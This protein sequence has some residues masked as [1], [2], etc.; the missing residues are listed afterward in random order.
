MPR[1]SAFDSLRRVPLRE[2]NANAN[3]RHNTDDPPPASTSGCRY[4][5]VADRSV[6]RRQTIVPRGGVV[7]PLFRGRRPF[8]RLLRR[9]P[10]LPRGRRRRR[11]RPIRG[12]GTA[13]EASRRRNALRYAVGG[14]AD[15]GLPDGRAGRSGRAAGVARRAHDEGSPAEPQRRDLLRHQA[16]TRMGSA[17]ARL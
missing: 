11:R 3:N 16:T 1:R 9:P 10:R 6:R 13:G 2:A 12:G 8:G 17:R 4:H 15:Q 14:G 5:H 7:A